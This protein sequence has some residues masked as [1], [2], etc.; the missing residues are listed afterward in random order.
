MQVKK[1]VSFF[2]YKSQEG[3]ETTHLASRFSTE[4][5]QKDSMNDLE[6]MA[7]VQSMK[8]FRNYV[9]GTEFEV[10]SNHKAL[11]TIHL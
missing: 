5:K 1:V 7:V 11:M 10:V 3:W 9:Y 8:Y 2:Y 6:I 4:F